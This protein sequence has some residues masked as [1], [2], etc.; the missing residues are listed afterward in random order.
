MKTKRNLIHASMII[1]VLLIIGTAFTIPPAKTYLLRYQLVKG[2]INKLNIDTKQVINISAE[3][4]TMVMNQS[5]ILDQTISVAD[6]DATKLTSVEIIYDRVQFKQNMM[7]MDMQWDSDVK[8]PSD[9]PMVQ[10]LESA[11]RSTIGAKTSMTI[12]SRGNTIKNNVSDVLKDNSNLAGFEAG[13][14]AVFPEN[15]IAVGESWESTYQPDPSGDMKIVARYKLDDV[16][17]G[18][19]YISFDGTMK[20]SQ[21]KGASAKIDGTMSGKSQINIETGWILSSTIIQSLNA[22]MEQ[23]GMTIPM[24]ISSTIEVSSK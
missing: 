17:K 16:K 15:P 24:K 13:M 5:I 12:D 7:G 18:I 21:M 10:Q 11:L 2:S 22:E 9:N 3:G 8:T 6:V 23:Q 1:A 14:M 20:G 4:Q 19:A